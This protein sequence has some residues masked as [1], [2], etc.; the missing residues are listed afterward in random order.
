MD[1]EDIV[2]ELGKKGELL[3]NNFIVI[4]NTDI[5]TTREF[6]SAFE[7]NAKINGRNITLQVALSAQ[8]PYCLPK[9][10]LKDK[11]YF[12]RMMPHIEKDGYICY[13]SSEGLLLNFDRPI[14]IICEALQ[15]AYKVLKDNVNGENLHDLYNEFEAFWR[16]IGDRKFVI[17]L[18]QPYAE[19]GYKGFYVWSFEGKRTKHNLLFCDDKEQGREYA[20]Q[21][22]SVELSDDDLHEGYFLMLRP[23]SYVNLDRLKQNFT[24]KAIRDILKENLSGSV[25]R[26]F[27]RRI[28]N[29]SISQGKNEYL[30]LGIPQPNGNIS[31]VGVEFSGFKPLIFKK[32]QQVAHPLHNTK[33]HTVIVTPLEVERHYQEH[34]VSRTGGELG[35]LKKKVAVLGAGAVGSRIVGELVHAGVNNITVIDKDMMSADNLYRHEVGAIYLNCNK[36][37]AIAKHLEFKYPLSDIEY[38]KAD[39]Y[40]LLTAYPDMLEKFDL[41]IIALGNPTIEMFLNRVLRKLEK[42]PPAIFTWVEPLGIGGHAVATLN[43]SN[44]GCY[45]CLHTN[46]GEATLEYIN[47]ASFAA[48]R[49]IFSKTVSGCGTQ[50]TP[51]GSLDALQTAILATRLAINILTGKEKDN[52]LLSWKGDA[53]NFLGEGFILSPRYEL[54][55]ELL[56]ETRYKY[57]IDRCPTCYKGT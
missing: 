48:P 7:C 17:S 3:C 35:M 11:S 46:P 54:S 34:L 40:D 55:Q 52:P 41:L 51:Y 38:K 14:E 10:F 37:Y 12:S 27:F 22:L 42:A 28:E 4:P 5:D 23:K 29:D 39:I 6:I 15:M 32:N 2:C 43:K 31:L 20:K 33:K 9:I 44:S 47:R 57:K 21:V 56:F 13:L 16:R 36:A 53:D 49:Q 1:V 50:F 24:A 26:R 45:D 19:R 8:F 18:V 25:R 30:L